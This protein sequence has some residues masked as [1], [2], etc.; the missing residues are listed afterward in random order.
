LRKERGNIHIKLAPLKTTAEDETKKWEL[1]IEDD[2]VG[3]PKSFTLDNTSSMGSQIIQTLVDQIHARIHFSG[4]EGA[5]FRIIF[6]GT[7][8]N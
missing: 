1:I 2:G 5:S 8:D 6:P 7:E 4:N 3:L